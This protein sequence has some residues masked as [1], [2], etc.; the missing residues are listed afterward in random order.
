MAA[1][2]A[3]S[4]P[5]SGR[6]P[7]RSLVVGTVIAGVVL[8]VLAVIVLIGLYIAFAPRSEDRSSLGPLRVVATAPA[9]HRP[10]SGAP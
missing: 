10:G 5:G 2:Q 8:A 9:I 1:P 7:Y 6:D 3:G 4:P